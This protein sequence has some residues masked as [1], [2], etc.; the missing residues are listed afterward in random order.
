MMYIAPPITNIVREQDTYLLELL[1]LNKLELRR[2]YL[3][4]SNKQIFGSTDKP[5]I[6]L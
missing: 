6:S 4:T 1:V 3:L 5:N 2:C